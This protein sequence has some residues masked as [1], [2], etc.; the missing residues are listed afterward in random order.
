MY[1]P[2]SQIK[3]NLYTNGDEFVVQS[4]NLPYTGFYWKNSSGQFYSGTTPDD[5]PSFQLLKLE[6]ELQNTPAIENANS[7]TSILALDDLSPIEEVQPVNFESVITYDTLSGKNL[8]SPQVSFL[9]Y[10]IAIKPTEQ[11]YQIGEFRRYFCKKTNEIQYI[12]INKTQYD[13]LLAKDPSI[14]WQLYLPFNLPWQ[15]TGDRE[16]V[17][18]TNKNIVD[19]TSKRLQLPKFGDYLKFDYIKYYR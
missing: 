11:D 7:Q 6:P 18:R 16:Q 13:L 3:T 10:Y 2:K 4:T 9:P 12:E 14:V 19:L 8:L 17:A 15:I 1:Y 5:R